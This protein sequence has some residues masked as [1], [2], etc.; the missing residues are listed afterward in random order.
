MAP[1]NGNN[2]SSSSGSN[3]A[4]S[5]GSNGARATPVAQLVEQRIPNPQ[6][7]GSIPSRRVSSTLAATAEKSHQTYGIYKYGQGYWVRMMTA[8]CLGILF[9]ATAG[10]AWNSLAA[11]RPPTPTW[12]F[13]IESFDGSAL[14][15]KVGERVTLQDS[16]ISP[17]ELLAAATVL[18]YEPGELG[19]GRL[20]VGSI[21]LT[22]LLN[23]TK[24]EILGTNSIKGPSADATGASLSS[25][26]GWG[27]KV[28]GMEGIPAF[29]LIYI[30]A[31][32]ALVIMVLG[33]IVVFF[34]VGRNANAVEYLI[35]TDGEMRKVNWSTKK[36]VVDSTY[37]VIIAAVIIAGFIFVSDILISNFFKVIDVIRA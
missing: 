37:I 26:G 2:P 15:A 23:G 3:G 32:V 7:A 29:Q 11:I 31:A 6:V 33:G 1:Q 20:V 4:G 12:S 19:K 13:K 25:A 22:M 35:A 34:Y 18:A 17:P 36:I 28:V 9:V 27:V 21:D 8:L 14:L 5:S 24:A 10:W 30:Q 16:N